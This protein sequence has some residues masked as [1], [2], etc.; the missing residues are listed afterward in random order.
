MVLCAIVLVRL[1]SQEQE[2]SV[3]SLSQK[4]SSSN[5]ALI[6]NA[7]LDS[8][9][10]MDMILYR[11]QASILEKFVNIYLVKKVTNVWSLG[12]QNVM[13]GLNVASK[14]FRVDFLWTHANNKKQNQ[15][16]GAIL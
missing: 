6:Q 8:N 1:E 12:N 14:Y 5:A 15:E 4:A 13:K 11:F 7:A 9:A 2:T 16:S 3:N 10:V